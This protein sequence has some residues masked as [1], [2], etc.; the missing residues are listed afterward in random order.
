ME[1]QQSVFQPPPENHR[2]I[3]VAT[4][5]AETSITIPNIRFVV[6]TGKVSCFW[7]FF[8]HSVY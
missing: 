7:L 1:R 2:L 3:V 4:N 6:D 5:V 8:F